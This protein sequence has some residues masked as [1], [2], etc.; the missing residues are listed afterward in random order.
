[1]YRKKQIEEKYDEIVYIAK[2]V[3]LSEY[4][5]HDPY[6]YLNTSGNDAPC[7]HPIQ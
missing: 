7:A 5:I 3:D 4:A 1:M 6:A 2:N